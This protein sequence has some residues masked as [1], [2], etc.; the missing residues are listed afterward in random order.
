MNRSDAAASPTALDDVLAELLDQI[1]DVTVQTD[2]EYAHQGVVFAARPAD[3]T[4][5]LRLGEDIVDAAMRT[6]DTTPSERGGEWLRFRPRELDAHAIDR[7]K[8]WFLVAYRQAEKSA[9]RRAGTK[10]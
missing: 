1:A 10:K 4:V 3:D 9:T 6:P 5:E 8:A 7:L 2:R